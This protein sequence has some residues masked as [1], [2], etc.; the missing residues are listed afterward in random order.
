MTTFCVGALFGIGLV[1]AQMVDPTK[2]LAFLDPV[3]GW[4]PSL[5]LVMGG[6]LMVTLLAFP[7]ILRRPG[8][9]LDMQFHLPGSTTIDPRLIGG[10][11]LFGLG[12]GLAGYCPGPAITALGFGWTEPW[13]FVAAMTAGSWLAGFHPKP[14][15]AGTTRH[16]G[17]RVDG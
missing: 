3:G 16:R 6:G 8:P 14:C 5:A 13:I 7:V 9:L 12:W 11:V 2:V 15:A 10:A 17:A 4:D 1:I